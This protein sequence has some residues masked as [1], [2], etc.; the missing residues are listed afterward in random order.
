MCL[1]EP[2]RPFDN[3]DVGYMITNISYG[4]RQYFDNLFSDYDVTYPQSRVLTRLF[5]QLGKGNVNQR[6]LEHALGIKASSVSS[7]VRNLENK[8]FITCERLP[9]DTRNKRVMLTD[10][11]LELRQTLYD[12]RNQAEALVTQGLTPEQIEVFRTC[13]R[14]VMTNLGAEQKPPKP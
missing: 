5:G 14:Q 7:L 13:L 4:I 11:G 2:S 6:D 8:G 3:P 12:A 1:M 10:K 9:E